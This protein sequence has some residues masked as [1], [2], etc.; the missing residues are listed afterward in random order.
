VA[1]EV[2]NFI[3]SAQKEC[4]DVANI[5]SMLALNLNLATVLSRETVNFLI[6]TIQ[7]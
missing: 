5:R 7:A 6:F 2:N 3:R 1:R 4:V